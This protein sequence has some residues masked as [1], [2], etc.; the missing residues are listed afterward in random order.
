V[1]GP[2]GPDGPTWGVSMAVQHFD[3]AGSIP[4]IADFDWTSSPAMRADLWSAWDGLR[5]EHR[6][7]RADFGPDPIWVLTRYEDIHEAFQTPDLFSNEAVQVNDVVGAHKWIPLELDPPEHGKYRQLLT[8]WFT[9][10]AATELAPRVRAW[11]RELIAGFADRG[12]CEFVGEFASLFP[13]TIFMGLMGLP[14][15]RAPELLGWIDRMMHTPADADPDGAIRGAA[16]ADVMVMLG[17]LLAARRAEPR[18]DLMTTIAHGEVDGAPLSDAEALEMSFLL[19]MAGLDTVAGALGTFFLHLA[20]NPADRRRI[21]AEPNIVPVAV[22]ELLRGYSIVTTGRLVTRDVEWHGCPMH[23]GD[24]VLLP[25]P[26]AN[27]DP[28]EFDDPERID[29]DRAR[30]RHFAFG[31]GP[32]RCLGSHLARVEL[33][34]AL[35]EWHARIPD[36]AVAEG[37]SIELHAGGVAGLDALPLV[38]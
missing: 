32:H 36:Y 19:Y 13:T 3:G 38:W 17:E 23:R 2:T 11:C 8:P 22:E 33:A 12:R 18:D 28:G 25:T 10:N 14:T 6:F 37:A 27:R 30:N 7:F 26:S 29:F 24:R 5:T 21:V 4:T 15:E 35:E 9:P 16:A 31:A 20:R 34:I 1:T